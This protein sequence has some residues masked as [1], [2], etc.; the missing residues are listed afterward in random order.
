MAVVST[1]GREEHGFAL[2]GM[3]LFARIDGLDC[4]RC[5]GVVTRISSENWFRD[6]G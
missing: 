6:S 2:M 1:G 3:G 5:C 4:R